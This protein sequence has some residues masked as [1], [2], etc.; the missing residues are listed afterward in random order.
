[1]LYIAARPEG[2]ICLFGA[3]FDSTTS[4]RPG[5]RFGPTALREASFSLETYSPIQDGD[6]TDVS[7][8]DL[9]DIELPFG[10][11][12]PAL[13][14][15]RAQ[16][17]T[18]LKASRIPFLFGGEHLVTLGVIQA[19]AET[20][21]DLKVIHLDAHADLRQDYL[22]QRLS[23]ATVMRRIADVI[24]LDNIRQI[25]IRSLDKPERE[26]V[27]KL[28]SSAYEAI[29]WTQACPC[30]I[31]CD[32]D[33]LD[34]SIFPGTGTPEPGGMTF[35]ELVQTLVALLSQVACVGLDV[36]ELAP[37]QDLSGVSAVVA[38]KVVRECL[39]ALG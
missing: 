33:I 35:L 32:L 16:A 39:I 23:H 14:L 24:G 7:F 18:I 19:L 30:Y 1:M 26:L 25:G 17:Q 2:K 3:P 8:M 10:D 6:L 29:T 31:T 15:I 11:P 20:Y 21:P 37:N 12:V 27:H 38:A 22:G 34:P 4:Y 36:V 5:S 9:G 13:A 28:K